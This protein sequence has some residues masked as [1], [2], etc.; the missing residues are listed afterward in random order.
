LDQLTTSRGCILV[1]RERDLGSGGEDLSDLAIPLNLY[2]LKAFVVVL[3]W[4]GC[5]SGLGRSIDL[6]LEALID[7]GLDVDTQIGP[8]VSL[9]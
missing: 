8:L 6:L 3:I 9:E 7:K 4:V 2:L 5:I 1:L